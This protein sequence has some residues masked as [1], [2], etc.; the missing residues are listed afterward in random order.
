MDDVVT[1]AEQLRIQLR[2]QA[3]PVRAVKLKSYLKS[4][5]EFYGISVAELRLLARDYKK[6]SPDP[7]KE[8]L[9]ELARSLWDTEYHEERTL[10]IILLEIFPRYLDAG[11]M[12]MLESMLVQCSTWDHVD[13]LS[14]MVVGRII[15]KDAGVLDYLRRWSRSE[16]FWMRR[17]A[18][19]AQ[20]RLLR[21]GDGDVELFLE[22]AREM[23]EEKEFFIRKAIG[24]VLR[25][26]SKA[27]PDIVYEFLLSVKDSAS[28]L[29]LREGSRRLPANLRAEVMR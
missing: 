10:A 21:R 12:P 22:F 8:H 28:G 23:I 29:T 9:N 25:E 3:D 2:F 27:K 4:P 24:W 16:S 13:A 19:I 15:E 20:L 18:L 17:A 11:N 6:G 1:Q 5:L 7:G 26:L 14:T